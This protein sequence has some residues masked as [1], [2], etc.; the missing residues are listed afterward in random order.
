MFYFIDGM[1][2]DEIM[3]K[4]MVFF[5]GVSKQ[6]MPKDAHDMA[7]QLVSYGEIGL[8]QQMDSI[9]IQM[10]SGVPILFVDGFTQAIA[11][12][13]RTYPARSIEEP[14]MFI[15]IPLI[16]QLLILEFAIDGL[17]LASMNTPSMRSRHNN[18]REG[19]SR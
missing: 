10:L 11:I 3:E 12:D 15:N 5:Y 8:E 17:K 16:F 1:N 14:E 4:I 6:D 13:F 7:K 18:S 19:D 2:K 9:I